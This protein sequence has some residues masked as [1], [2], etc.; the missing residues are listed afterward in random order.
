MK[1]LSIETSCDETAAAVTEGRRVLSNVVFSQINIHKKYGGVYP[2]LAKRAHEEKLPIVVKKAVKNAGIDLGEIGAI[3]V[4]FGPGLVVAL[5]VGLRKAKKLASELKKPLIPVNHLEAHFYSC[6]AQNR[7]GRPLR[8]FAFPFLG[9][10]VSGGHTS[11]ILV[12]NHL[13]YQVLGQTLDDACGEAL[14]KA[15]KVLGLGYP[16]GPIME[17]LSLKGDPDFLDLPVP[18]K[19]HP[20]LNLSYSGLKTSFKNRVARL[21][22]KTVRKNLPGLA[23]S[24][25]QVAFEA[26]LVKLKRALLTTGTKN[27]VAGGGVLANKKLRLLIKQLALKLGVKVFFPPFPKLVGDNAAMVGVAGYYKYQ[28][29]IYLKKNFDPLDRI[30][31]PDL[32]LWTKNPPGVA[33]RAR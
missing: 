32:N 15:A 26:I 18:M 13:D 30:A 4:T 27:L 24:F 1:I 16:G 33:K 9:L 19:T 20:G 6:W 22:Q 2:A 31:R 28:E 12:K 25:Q 5:E 11:L 23:A 17:E 29:G 3:A 10:V 8:E 14:D 21:S 7:N